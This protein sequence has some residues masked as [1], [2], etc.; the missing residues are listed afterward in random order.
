MLRGRPKPQLLVSP[1]D[2]EHLVRW[3]RRRSTSNGLARRAEIVLRWAEGVS[4]R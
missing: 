1:D 3:R 2:R 4:N